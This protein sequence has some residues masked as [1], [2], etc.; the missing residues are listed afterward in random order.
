MRKRVTGVLNPTQF[1]SADV[2]HGK[3][4]NSR[5]RPQ[6]RTSPMRNAVPATSVVVCSPSDIAGHPGAPVRPSGYAGEHIFAGISS[7]FAILLRQLGGPAGREK[8]G[9]ATTAGPVIGAGDRRRL[10]VASN[11]STL[12]RPS[13]GAPARS[14]APPA[15]AAAMFF[16][17]Y[18]R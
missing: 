10:L 13:S 18:A 8:A 17:Y 16:I 2:S 1:G 14:G 4:E 9:V 11:R 12:W 15:G 5:W 6:S 7:K 3:T